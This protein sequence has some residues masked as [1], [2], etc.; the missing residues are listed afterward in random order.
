MK[1]LGG[2]SDGSCVKHAK[3]AQATN[4]DLLFPLTDFT[5]RN[6]SVF[7]KRSPGR[8]KGP[9][10]F[11]FTPPTRGAVRLLESAQH[12]HGEARKQ[13]ITALWMRRQHGERS[14]LAH[15]AALHGRAI[16]HAAVACVLAG[17]LSLRGGVL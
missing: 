12:L 16:T 1:H 2:L 5:P 13:S 14:H 3:H 9:R 10:G 11:Y 7:H 8:P 4:T 15:S 6:A 17:F